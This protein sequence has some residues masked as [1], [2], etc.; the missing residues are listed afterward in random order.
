MNCVEH[1]KGYGLR[2]LKLEASE[3]ENQSTDILIIGGGMVGLCIAR[4]LICSKDKLKVTIL[5]K[6]SE[7]GEHSSGRNS[8]VIHSG[9]YYKSGTLKARVCSQ[10]GRKLKEWV[11]KNDLQINECGKIITP[12]DIHLDGILDELE[13]RGKSN[14]VAAN[15]I[16]KTE[17]QKRFPGVRTAT[18]R[19]LFVQ[20]TA[21]VNPKKVLLKLKGELEEKQVKF[22]FNEDA[23]ASEIDEFCVKLEGGTRIKYKYLFNCAGLGADLVAHKLDIGSEY[24]IMPFKGLYWKIKCTSELNISTN[25]YPV[26]DLNLPFLGVHFTPNAEKNQISIGPTATFA[27]GRENYQRLEGIEPIQAVSNLRKLCE[28]YI[29]NKGGIREYVHEQSMLAL[30]PFLVESARKLIPAIKSSDLEVSTKVGIRSQLFNNKTMK[31]END[32]ICISKTNSTHVLNAISPAFT[33]GFALA[34]EIIKISGIC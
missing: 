4:A 9:I 5:E 7:I 2:F 27:F 31:L 13:V 10:G 14:G 18:D 12:Q 26:P 15:I 33:S 20:T 30:K 16:T 25:V 21:V 8:G 23:I 29:T 22:I 17:L 34:D 11:K 1:Q 3:L 32:F 19:A 28:L 24:T 6:E